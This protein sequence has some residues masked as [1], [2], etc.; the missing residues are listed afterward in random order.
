MMQSV[1]YGDSKAGWIG[2]RTCVHSRNRAPGFATA[3]ISLRRG[4]SSAGL[5][6]TFDEAALDFEIADA[7]RKVVGLRLA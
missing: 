6:R 7:A 4:T 5:C 2:I 1:P 3:V